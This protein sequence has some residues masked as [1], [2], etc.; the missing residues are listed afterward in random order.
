MASI[1]DMRAPI[2]ASCG[3]I[4]ARSSCSWARSSA[5]RANG[6][7]Q[8]SLD[9]RLLDFAPHRGLQA[10]LRDLNHVYRDHDALYARDCEAEGF[11]WI[12]VDDA[13][14]SVFAFARFG[15]DRS[16]AIVVVSEFHAGDAQRL[17][18]SACRARDAGVN[19]SIPTLR[20]MAARDSAISAPFMRAPKRSAT[21]PRAPRFFCRRC[22]LSSS[23]SKAMN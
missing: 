1:R 2:T 8:A 14:S 21:F 10:F 9:W 6:I 12:V 13:E 17:S 20:S 23:H 7:S 15:A 4:P 11:Q 18:G 19:S 5:R 22:R 3:A 16:R